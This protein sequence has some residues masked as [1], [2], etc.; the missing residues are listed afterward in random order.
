MYQ[1]PSISE[2]NNLD[3]QENRQCSS[4]SL[5]PNQP[6]LQ[7]NVGKTAQVESQAIS[8]TPPTFHQGGGGNI[9]VLFAMFMTYFLSI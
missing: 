6:P 3:I 5:A 4:R 1:V 9:L 7:F 2:Q 8:T